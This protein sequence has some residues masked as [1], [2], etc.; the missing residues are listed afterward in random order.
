[1]SSL[2]QLRKE[3]SSMFV[4][5]VA[6]AAEPTVKAGASGRHR[7]PKG[8]REWACGRNSTRGD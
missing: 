3:P 4:V 7:G 8:G 2:T 1:M 6:G 5:A